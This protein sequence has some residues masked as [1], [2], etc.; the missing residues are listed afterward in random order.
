MSDK[1]FTILAIIIVVILFFMGK[2]AIDNGEL[3]LYYT[4]KNKTSN[5]IVVDIQNNDNNMTVNK[6]Y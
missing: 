3:N 5:N 6:V 1:I 2:K 4:D